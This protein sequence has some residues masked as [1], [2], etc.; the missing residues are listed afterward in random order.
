M[1]KGEVKILVADDNPDILKLID[2]NLKYE[3]Y[4]TITAKDGEKALGL[5]R[6][7]KPDL[8]IL[9]ILMPVMDGWQVLSNLKNSEETENIPVIMLTGL[10]MKEGKERGLIEGVE[11]FLSKPF[12]PLRLLEIVEDIISRYKVIALPQALYFKNIKI[13]LI[14]EGKLI[15]DMA[16]A[17]MGSPKIELLAFYYNGENGSSTSILEKLKVP[18]VES[19]LEMLEVP[20]IELIIDTCQTIEQDLINKSKEKEIDILSGVPVHLVLTLLEDQ[21]TTRIKEKSLVKELNTRVKELSL[22]NEMSQ[23]LTSP[24]NLWLLLDKIARLATKISKVDA[25]AILMYNEEQEKFIVSNTLGLS[26]SFKENVKLSLFDSIIEEMMTL[27]RPLVVTNLDKLGISPLIKESFREGMK[28]MVAV[29]L[30]SKG[31][32]MAIIAIYSK[33]NRELPKE[34]MGLLTILA[35]QAG[36]SIENADLYES[37]HQKQQLVEQLLGK[38]IQ[39]QEEERKRIAAELHD[40]IAQSLVGILTKVQTCQ[41]LMKKDPSQV[42]GKLEELKNVVGDNVKEVRQIIFNLRPSSLDDLGLVPSLENYIKRFEKEHNIHVE[43]R[44]NNRERRLPTTVETAV[45]RIIQEAL[46]NVRKH[47]NAD[48][49]LVRLTFQPKI[50]SLRIA[51]NGEGFEWEEVTERFMKGHS[52]GIQGMKERV[53]VLGGTFKITT[54]KGKGCVVNAQVPIYRKKE[55]STRKTMNRIFRG[56]RRPEVGGRMTDN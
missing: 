22:L 16:R 29:P 25:C 14:G 1:D 13:G 40:T 54:E 24:L 33:E 50:L 38:V 36:I 48:K 12:N 7:H 44:I 32:L 8:I 47:S 23:I 52:H 41:L 26:D 20:G 5:A 18:M 6:K 46:T 51:D 19:P 17:L 9:D 21:Q 2:L 27:N 55:K 45:F 10:S 53:S 35:G 49:T 42:L 56:D 4:K 15:V 31:K 39:A 11:D 30:P 28:N 34:A 3:G 43:F 37:T